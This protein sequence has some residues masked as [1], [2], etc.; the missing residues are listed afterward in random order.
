MTPFIIAVLLLA[1]LAGAYVFYD[2]FTKRGAIPLAQAWRDYTSWLSLVGIALAQWIV[3]LLRYMADLWAPAQQQFG[4]L[5]DQPSLA[6][7]IQLMSFV[8]MA[9]KL[10]GQTPLPRP[11]LPDMP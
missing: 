1:L 2:R 3:E 10:K 8:F 7:M 5:L 6:M 4:A 9:L 11:S